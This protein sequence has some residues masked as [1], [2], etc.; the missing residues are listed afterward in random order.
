M[1]DN[2]ILVGDSCF[3]GRQP[4]CMGDGFVWAQVTLYE[5][6]ILCKRQ[7]TFGGRPPILYERGSYLGDR[8]FLVGAHQFC[9]SAD[10]T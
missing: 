3:G 8:S 1:D 6:R 10:L 5:R 9:M 4:I 7:V 2:Q